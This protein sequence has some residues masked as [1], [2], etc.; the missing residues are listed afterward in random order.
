MTVQR[1]Y[2]AM[3]LQNEEAKSF[4]FSASAP[5]RLPASVLQMRGVR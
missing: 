1:R 3:G 5:P 4:D 2:L